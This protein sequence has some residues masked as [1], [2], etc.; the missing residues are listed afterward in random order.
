MVPYGGGADRLFSE[1]L[2]S[3]SY[4]AVLPADLSSSSVSAAQPAETERDRWRG[5]ER[6]RERI[7]QWQAATVEVLHLR[8]ADV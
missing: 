1:A 6:A 7:P 2:P 8:G 3:S 5:N 4:T